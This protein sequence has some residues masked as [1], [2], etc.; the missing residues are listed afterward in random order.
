[1]SVLTRRQLLIGAA[2]LPLALRSWAS[3]ITRG[4]VA[5]VGGGFGGAVCARTLRRLAPQL[6]IT[7]VEPRTTF[8]TGPLSN[9]AVSGAWAS[10]R[11]QR[12][13][14]PMAQQ[15]GIRWL[16]TQ[17][18]ALDPNRRELQLG[19][20]SRLRADRIVVS[21]GV[22]MRYEDIDGLSAGTSDDVPH[23]WLGDAQVNMLHA[24][25][26]A[27][28]DGATIVIAAPPMPYRCPPGPYERAALIAWRLQQRGIR[29]T[30][31]LVLDAKD[32]FTK[33]AVIQAAWAELYPG[34]V[35]WVSRTAGGEVTGVDVARKRLRLAN[36]ESVQA[37]LI[38]LVP[39]QEAAAFAHDAA[40]TDASGWCP[41]YP[42]SFESTRHPGIHVIGDACI[43]DPMPKSAF[44]AGA[45]ARQC[46]LAIIASLR[47][48]PA[49]GALLANTCFSLLAPDYA[50]SV[51][52][53]YRVIDGRLNMLSSGTSPTHAPR[54]LREREARY[55][56]AWYD[57]ATAEAFG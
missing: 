31:I 47:G 45:Q 42:S 16:R 49:P 55:A 50:V 13:P 12:T 26:D 9:L 7:L 14:Q 8:Y 4:H 24:R 28:H 15:Q 38:S 21:P 6:D 36:S 18:V 46:A 35:E 33:R 27:L 32:D 20:G 3:P 25:I 44:S 43:A 34:V 29:N 1:M 52:A 22:R 56:Y 30:C 48:E 5:I 51:S 54:S 40:L 2:A 10:E 11:V 23:A 39:P 53:S 19:D 41:V 57:A 37:D 17:A